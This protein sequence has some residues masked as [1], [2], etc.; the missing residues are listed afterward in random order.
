MAKKKS[1]CQAEER[2]VESFLWIAVI[3]MRGGGTIVVRWLAVQSGAVRCNWYALRRR[4]DLID[5]RAETKKEI[6]SLLLQ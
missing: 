2:D 1:R 6:D 3:G 5:Q 4:H